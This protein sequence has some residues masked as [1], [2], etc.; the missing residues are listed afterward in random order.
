[1]SNFY[2]A[3]HVQRAVL[4]D[5]YIPDYRIFLIGDKTPTGEFSRRIKAVTNKPCIRF[6]KRE[7]MQG[8]FKR[9][10]VHLGLYAK[11]QE[12]FNE[13]RI[14]STENKTETGRSKCERRYWHYSY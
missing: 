4:L 1:M 10:P 6:P 12:I 11:K 5:L 14:L 9:I 2:G 8:L 3:V 7:W 13:R